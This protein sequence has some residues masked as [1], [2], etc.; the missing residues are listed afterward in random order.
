[1]SLTTP[2][3]E[4]RNM[5]KSSS[6]LKQK[7]YHEMKEFFLVAFYLWVVFGLFIMYKCSRERPVGTTFLS[8]PAFVKP[9]G[10]SNKGASYAVPPLDFGKSRKSTHAA[11]ESTNR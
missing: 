4:K 7:A 10:I 11:D 8:A 3:I 6:V 5:S 1:M 2:R 9:G